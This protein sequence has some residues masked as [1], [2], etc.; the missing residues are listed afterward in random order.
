M[1]GLA[2]G[3]TGNF[4]NLIG[5]LGVDGHRQEADYLQNTL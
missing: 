4:S 2:R 5:L 3:G 1:G